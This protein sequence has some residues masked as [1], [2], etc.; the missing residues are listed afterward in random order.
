MINNKFQRLFLFFEIFAIDFKTCRSL[1]NF[2]EIHLKSKYQEILLA[3]IA[4]DIQKSLFSFT[5]DIIN[6]F[7]SYLTLCI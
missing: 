6:S 4:V 5:F 1:L 7:A 3:A 2:N